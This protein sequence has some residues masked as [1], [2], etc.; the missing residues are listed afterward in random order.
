MINAVNRELPE[1]IGEYKV[2]PYE[3]AYGEVEEKEIVTRRKMGHML[4]GSS[5]LVS[6]LE[7][8]IVK[9][10]LKDGMTISFH[11]CLREEIRLSGRCWKRSGSLASVIFGLHPAQS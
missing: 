1:K 10:G 5:K 7:E 11:H 3:Q 9:S 6:G 2:R 4:P 8:A